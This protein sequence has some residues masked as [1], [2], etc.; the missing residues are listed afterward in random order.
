MQRV[1]FSRLLNTIPVLL[2]V[3]L[4]SFVLLHLA[5]GDPVSMYMSNDMSAANPEDVARVRQAMGLNEPLPVQYALWLGHALQGDLGFS[6]TT[7][8]PVLTII[9]EA[10][11]NCCC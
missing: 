5:P 2:I 7:R 10:L 1:I 3:S 11:P 6:L 8:R 9:F 4:V